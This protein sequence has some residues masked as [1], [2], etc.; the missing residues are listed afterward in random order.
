MAS[1]LEPMHESEPYGHLLVRGK[2]PD[3]NELA[4]IASCKLREV[5]YGIEELLKMGVLSTNSDGIWY[6]RRMVRDEERRKRQSLGGTRGMATRQSHQSLTMIHSPVDSPVVLEQ[7]VP[8]QVPPIEARSQKLEA[9]E[10]RES[11]P[12]RTPDRSETRTPAPL[13]AQSAHRN[14]AICGVVCLPAAMYEDFVAR[15]RHQADPRKYVSDF[16]ATWN[17]RY[18]S[19]DRKEQVISGD[20]F[21]F[22]RDRWK[23]T[24]AAADKPAVVDV[25]AL[26]WQKIQADK[27]RYGR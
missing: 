27:A 18:Q 13:I 2:K 8:K 23:E 21:T 14:H 20:A 11:A 4:V 10:E 7:V 9:R 5:K 3:F 15:S 17:T 25:A 19:G 26:A 24:H 1:L 12:A 22:W 16:F 6:S